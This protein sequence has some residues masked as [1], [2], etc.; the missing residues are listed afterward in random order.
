MALS[1]IENVHVSELYSFRRGQSYT[2]IMELRFSTV[3]AVMM[4]TDKG[5]E[6]GPCAPLEEVNIASEKSLP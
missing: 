3:F 1:E 2:R 4:K 6:M 5:E